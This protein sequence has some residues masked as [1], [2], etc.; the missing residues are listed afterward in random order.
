MNKNLS[1]GPVK[2]NPN[3][4]GNES[5]DKNKNILNDKNLSFRKEKSKEIS[6]KDGSKDKNEEEKEVVITPEENENNN[7]NTFIINPKKTEVQKDTT[8]EKEH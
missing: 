5:N 1:N 3:I 2:T 4:S 7:E 6:G 8:Y